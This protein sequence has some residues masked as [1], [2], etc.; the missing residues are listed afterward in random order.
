GQEGME[1]RSS[2]DVASTVFAFSPPRAPLT[3][4][5]PVTPLPTTPDSLWDDDEYYSC[6]EN[7]DSRLGN[8]EEN[9]SDDSEIRFVKSNRTNHV[10]ISSDDEEPV[11]PTIVESKGDI[12]YI[13]TIL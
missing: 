11:N 12:R 6:D 3:P 13:E 10:C 1:E 5:T 4:M 8:G 9:E 7:R 2:A